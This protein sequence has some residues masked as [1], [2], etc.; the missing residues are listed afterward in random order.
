MSITELKTPRGTIPFPAYIPVTTFGGKYPLD[1]LIRPYLPRLASAV[2]V[3]YHYAQQMNQGVNIPIMIDSGG[4]ASLFDGAKI[5]KQNGLGILEYKTD[6]DVKRLHPLEILDF[7]E[8]KADIAF[9]LD[10]IIPPNMKKRESIRRMDLTISNAIWALENCRRKEM[11][12]YASI[13]AW[14]SD[15]AADCAKQYASYNFDGV[16]IGGLVPRAKDE[17]L[18]FKIVNAVRKEIPNKPIHVFGIGK[19]SLVKQ[20]FDKGVSSVDS[21][22]YVRYAASGKY[23]WLKEKVVSEL[24]PTTILNLALCNLAQ[25][26]NAHIPLLFSTCILKHSKKISVKDF[27]S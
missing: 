25:A 16:A 9:T 21:S 4:F 10:F 8:K 22:S 15:S 1:N 14:D 3:S 7:Q 18:I 13:Q 20:L 6:D 12:L 11:K 19:P 5:I 17:K 23:F 26:T 27:I 2:M 24:S